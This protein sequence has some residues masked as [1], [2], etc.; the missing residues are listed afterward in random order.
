MALGRQIFPGKSQFFNAV[1]DSALAEPF[2]HLIIDITPLCA[3]DMRLR[4]R[5]TIKGVTG[6]TVF[7]QP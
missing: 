5:A 4:Q 3:D 1:L 2:S 7:C 6:F